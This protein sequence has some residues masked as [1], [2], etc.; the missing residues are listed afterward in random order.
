M[1]AVNKPKHYQGD[2]IECID[3]I[4]A[5]LGPD[6]FMAYCQGNVMKYLWRWESKG[7]IEDLSKASVYLSWLNDAALAQEEAEQVKE[8]VDLLDSRRKDQLSD[9][10]ILTYLNAVHNGED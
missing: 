3:A 7:G 10:E 8:K 1:D 9:F 4:E 6:G 5:A 2:G